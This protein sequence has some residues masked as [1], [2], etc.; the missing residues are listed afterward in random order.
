MGVLAYSLHHKRQHP[1][2]AGEKGILMALDPYAAAGGFDL[3]VHIR[4]VEGGCGIAHKVKEIEFP[5]GRGHQY[6]LD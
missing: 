6:I 4:V 1:L 3:P 2:P 5:D